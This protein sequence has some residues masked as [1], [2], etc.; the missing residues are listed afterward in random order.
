LSE[1]IDNNLNTN[2]SIEEKITVKKSTYNNLLKG[3]VAA[4]AIQDS[5]PC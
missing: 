3:I 4:I 5:I 2:N 1:G